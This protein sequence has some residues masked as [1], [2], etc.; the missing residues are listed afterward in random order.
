MKRTLLG[1]IVVFAVLTAPSFAQPFGGGGRPRSSGPDRSSFRPF[2]M[3]SGPS[4]EAREGE[5]PTSPGLSINERGNV[6]VNLSKGVDI[7]Q[8]V[9]FISEQTKKPV[10]KSTI[11]QGKITIYSAG[12]IPPDQ[13][14]QR[15]YEALELEGVAVIETAQAIRLVPADVAKTM[16]VQILQPEDSAASLTHKTQIVQKIFKLKTTSPKS[17]VSALQPLI[18]KQGSIGTDERTKTVVITD[19]AANVERMEY[20]VAALDRVEAGQVILKT[21][22]LQ[23]ANA[24]ELADLVAMMAV[25]GEGGALPVSQQSRSS[26]GDDYYRRRYGGGTSG[27]RMAGDVVVLP[28]ARTNWLIVAGPPDKVNRIEMMVKEVDVPGRSDVDVHILDVKHADADDL[29]QDIRDMITRKIQ[30]EKQEVFD[31]RSNQRGNQLLILSTPQTYKLVEQLVKEMDTSQSVQRETRTYE[32]KYIDATDMADQLTQ[33]Y[34]SDL[35]GFGGFGFFGSSYGRSSSRNQAQ[36]VPSVRTNSLMVIA[37]PSEYEFIERMI[38][39]LDVPTA[40]ENLAPRVYHIVHTDA[41]EMVTV[42][43]ELFEGGAAR[44]TG[45]SDFYFWRPRTTSGR[46][47]GVGALY[48]KVRFVVYHATNS[49]V[50]ITNNPQNF[51]AIEGLIK[52]LDVLDPESTNML[53][54]QIQFADVAELS[55]NLNNLLSEGAV[56][57]PSSQQGRSTSSQQGGQS[58]QGSATQQDQEPPPPEVIFPWQ[59]GARRTPTRTGQEE[60]PISSLI[61]H[62]RIIPDIRSQKLVIAAPSIYFDAIKQLVADLDKPEPQVQLETYIV[63]VDTEGQLR[64]GW[65]WMP[66]ASTVSPD[67]LDNAIVGLLDMGFIDT[68]AGSNPYTPAGTGGQPGVPSPVTVTGRS[69]RDAFTGG[70]LFTYGQSLKPGKGVFSADV[71]LALLI[72]L[73]IKNRNASVVA[74]P[75]I[76]VNNNSTGEVFVGESAPFQ[77]GSVVSTEG[78]SAQ[79]TVQYR[80]VGTRLNIKPQINKQGRVVLKVTIEN[81]RRKP[82]LLMGQPVTEVQNYTTILTVENGQKVWLG[83]LTEQRQDNAVRK[84]PLLGDIPFL[85]YLFQKIDKVTLESKIYAFIT[86]TVIETAEQADAQFR[87]AKKEI[88]AYKKEY[89]Q[90]QLRMPGEENQLT[91]ATA[92]PKILPSPTSPEQK[93]QK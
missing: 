90:L 63:R 33:L 88:D 35:R 29:A 17:L 16:R 13:A 34:Q 87:R 58:S 64:I 74:H 75:Q 6:I 57:R 4:T 62:V 3:E 77:T 8:I 93:E 51:P 73:L 22:K 5:G 53:V 89:E 67:E 19:S 43:S 92:V 54:I 23:Y 27:G 48:G 55:N 72:Q 32:L 44:R 24:D 80:D 82:E 25:A 83:G 59:S 79:T 60:R 20:L 31:V 91:S 78:R 50:A 12:K 11:V 45:S 52:E 56:T 84:F 41:S 30:R 7:T 49:I 65:R 28:D 37:Q 81:S 36:F 61:N 18:G 21:F 38:K 68:F 9:N 15:I 69:V 86:P 2:G 40:E 85:G 70:N 47:E 71:N 76:T 26:Y 14:L 39:E 10:L 1:W 46:Q 66:D 42:L